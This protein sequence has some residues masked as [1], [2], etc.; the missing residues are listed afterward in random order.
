MLSTPV[1]FADDLEL[2]WRAY[3]LRRSGQPI[4]LS[5]IPMELLFLLVERRGELVTR[6]EIVARIWGK[7]VFLD[8]D[9]SINAAV[10]KLRQVLDD[11]PEHPRYLQTVTR[12]GYRFIAPV[13]EVSPPEASPATVEEKAPEAGNLVGKKVSHYRV[14]QVL[15]GGGMGVVYKAEDLKLGRKVAIKFLPVELASDPN[16]FERLEREARAA[17]ALEHPNICPIYELGEHEGQPFIVMQLLEGQTL[18]ER[19]ETAS[20][21][22]KP[23]PTSEML[24]LA[25][26]IAAGLEAAHTKGIIHR[27]VKPANIFITKPSEVKI[28]DFGLAKMI[29]EDLPQETRDHAALSENAAVA[30]TEA[31]ANLRLTR[32]GT[33]VG[34]AHYMSPEQVRGE[35]LD[36]RTDMFSFGLVL[37]EMATGQRAFPGNTVVLVHDAILHREVL[38]ARQANPELPPG[39]EQIIGKALEKDRSLRYQRADDLRADLQR[40]KRETESGLETV[41]RAAADSSAIAA[42]TQRHRTGF[43]VGGLV[44]VAVLVAAGFGLYSLLTR[45]GPQPFKDFTV[46]QIT[47]TGKAEMAAI[48]P[49]G[50]YILHVQNENGLRSLRLRNILTGSDTQIVAPA[51]FRYEALVF[52][53]DSNYVYFRQLTNSAG[54]SWD[55]YRLPVLG[56]TPQL[57]ASDVDSDITFSPDARRISYVRANDP[58]DGKYRLLSANPDGTDETILAIEKIEGVGN[59]SYPV[60]SAWSADGKRIAYSYAKMA[61]Q[62]GLIKSFD[63]SSKRL[64]ALERLPNALTFEVRWLR[65]DR[66]L[67]LLHAE[68]G[69]NFG[70]PQI[71]EVSVADGR[72]YPLTRDTNSYFTLTLSADGK[73]AATV[74]VKTADTLN[75]FPVPGHGIHTAAVPPS[76]I[77]DV[78][79]F[80]W[81][82]DGKL[83]V[84]DGSR[85][86]RVGIDGVKETVLTSDPSAAVLS[87]VRCSDHYVL[88]SWAYRG[89]GDERTIWRLNTDG[90]NPKQLS[91]GRY[92]TS[93][94]CSPDGKWAYYLD[95][96]RTLM[97]VPVEGGQAEVVPG[98][99]VADSYQLLGSVDFSPDGRH[100]VLIA[101]THDDSARAYAKLAIVDL[102]SPSASV[103]HIIDPDPRIAAGSLFTGGARFGPDG[104]SLVYVVK[105][106]AANLW[107]QPLDGSP[108]HQI[109]N[110]T[111]D[112]ITGFRWSPDRKTLAVMR[113]HS[114]SDVVVLRETNE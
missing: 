75:L 35:A 17:S 72:F 89:G 109:T 60:F 79:A 10:R 13:L 108:G 32:T 69:P 104:K 3:E 52:S 95:S 54:S 47:N 16:S 46:S 71:G 44:A 11:D 63:L 4:R 56:G 82:A 107:M 81:T 61:D 78:N 100:L 93:P 76:Q 8:T 34:T 43:A 2:D 96:L 90:S 86:L 73:T 110:F 42:F 64:G 59:E 87:L 45:A 98:S 91:G 88:V 80:D 9:N 15:G 39:L 74:Q 23:L 18:Q 57:I 20:Q 85:L 27:D 33:T 6:D 28:L 14:L 113:T 92:G 97:R 55:V 25:L 101:D 50:K 103:P 68:K 111:S 5:R 58:D 7:D 84:S 83:I 48:S 70:S 29:E 94:S 67:M 30:P 36:P 22:K 51:P 21:Q 19:I 40:L 106:K 31:L 77:E 62:P 53:P 114:T 41:S 1:K 26:Q 102:D 66:W 65:G 38:P 49:D 24:D 105:D 12:M 112:L 37:Y 99:K